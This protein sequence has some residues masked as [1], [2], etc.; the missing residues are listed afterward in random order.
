MRKSE[1]TL[2][3]FSKRLTQIVLIVGLINLLTANSAA[4]YRPLYDFTGDARTDFTVLT[5]QN[6]SGSQINWKTLRNPGI[7]GPG[8]AF[9][10][11]FAF[12]RVPEQITAADFIGDAKTDISIYRT[13]EF[14][15]YET[16]F[17]ETSVAL[18]N[19]VN[20]GQAGDNIGRD[21]DYDGDG[22]DDETIV[23][24]V[25]NQLQWWYKGTTSGDRV[26]TFGATGVNFA[27]FAFQGAD[28]TNDGRDELVICQIDGTDA[29]VRWFV[30]DSVTGAPVLELNWGDFDFDY[31]INPDDYTGDGFADLAVWRAGGEAR[32]DHRAWYIRDT[33]TGAQLPLVFFG[34]GGFVGGDIP[35]RGNYDG[36]QKADI[37]VFRPSTREWFWINSSNGSL[38][39]QQWGDAGDTPLPNFFNF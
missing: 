26:V 19:Y 17:P 7:P 36:D 8:N 20:W 38:G 5:L 23:R 6:G 3:F 32:P 4:V 39:I 10:R 28:F 18:V 33:T 12:G 16:L 24:V 27:T 2:R 14:Q 1:N 34:L 25:S 35:L 21:G 22:K 11:T 13:S 9:I 30:G 15:F 31:L 37:A 29:S